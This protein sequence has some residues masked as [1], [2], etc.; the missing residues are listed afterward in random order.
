MRNNIAMLLTKYVSLDSSGDEVKADWRYKL[1]DQ[2]VQ[3]TATPT[4]PS[5]RP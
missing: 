4:S 3:R 1:Y 2:F 5:R